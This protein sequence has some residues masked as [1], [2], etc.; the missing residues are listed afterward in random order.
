MFIH[1]CTMSNVPMFMT[2]ERVERM[3]SRVEGG[4]S[5][6]PPIFTFEELMKKGIELR[7]SQP[8]TDTLLSSLSESLGVAITIRVVD[9]DSDYEKPVPTDGDFRSVEICGRL[10][11][12]MGSD[13][14]LFAAIKERIQNWLDDTDEFKE[15]HGDTVAQ[16]GFSIGTNSTVYWVLPHEDATEYEA[17]K[18]S[19]SW[20]YDNPFVS[21]A[22]E[23]TLPCLFE[24]LDEYTIE[25]F[26]ELLTRW[27]DMNLDYVYEGE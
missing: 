2:P 15:A 22:K 16:M 24:K 11:R 4:S 17:E 7:Q 3:R 25:L 8:D 12:Q 18:L 5:Y 27:R 6:Q 9:Y 14:D 10:L 1:Q 19:E 20:E 23:R 26:H 21:R 13:K